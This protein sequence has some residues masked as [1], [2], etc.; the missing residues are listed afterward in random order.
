MLADG[1]RVND[2]SRRQYSYNSPVYRR[3]C[4]EIVEAL[5]QHY[6]NNTNIIGWQIDNEINNVDP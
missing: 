3:F 6:R 5:A 2:Q 1:Q 4:R